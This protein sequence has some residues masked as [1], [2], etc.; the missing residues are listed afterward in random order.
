MSSS[1]LV[2]V[3]FA[4]VAHTHAFADAENLRARGARLVSMWDADDPSAA[5]EFSRRFDVPARPDV[6]ALLADRP[7]VVVVTVRTPRAAIVS[8]ACSAANVPA[9]FNK[10]VAADECALERW[11]DSGGA[12][13]YTT[14]VLRFAPA[15]RR[16][17]DELRDVRIRAVDIVA[18]HDISAF[19]HAVRRWQDD[20]AGAGGTL[21]NIG[22]HAWE[23]LDVLLPDAR[24]RILSARA[25]RG[26][27][28]TASELFA[29]VH[30]EV[31]QTTVS[32]TVSGVPGPDHYAVRA[33]T[34][35]GLRCVRL[36][37]DARALGY[38]GAAE[39]IVRLARTLEPA[40]EEG[41]TLAVYAN[42]LA[43]ARIARGA[44]VASQT[45]APPHQIG[46]HNGSASA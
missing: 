14:S 32:V 5:T 10:T 28:P 12:P 16:L 26:A 25:A 34:D 44:S 8:A 24:A 17:A 13:R 43:A 45:V 41:R 3:A 23:M 46:E 2:R 1:T 33:L 15:L 7:D 4:G 19:L 9:F 6:A 39:G 40:V 30:A 31:A 36:A 29:T 37:T 11:A 20:P 27:S 22:I 42:T 18:Q 35:D 38:D 21:I